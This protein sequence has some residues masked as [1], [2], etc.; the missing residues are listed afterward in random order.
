MTEYFE[1]YDEDN[2]PLHYLKSRGDVHRDGDWHRT[3]QVFV[4]NQAEQ[5]LCNL[6]SKE[7]DVYPL[8][9][10]ISVGGHAAP[11]ES[12]LQTALRELREELGV[13]VQP[14]ELR[15]IMHCSL[16]GKDESTQHIDREH[17]A[18][19]LYKTHLHTDDFKVAEDEILSLEFFAVPFIKQNLRANIPAMRFVPLQEIYTHL[20]NKIEE[21]IA[22]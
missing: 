18:V 21:Q 3:I 10:D 14:Q 19:F 5:V 7:K 13:A 9:W 22:F 17:A 12:S 4:V 8:C 20:L 16:N 11:G 1:I 6:R 15:F 2:Q